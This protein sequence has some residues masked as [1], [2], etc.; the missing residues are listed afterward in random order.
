MSTSSDPKS[1]SEK[2]VLKKPNMSAMSMKKY[3]SI[4]D[5]INER[6]DEEDAAY[7]CQ[8]ICAILKFDPSIGLASKERNEYITSWRKQKMEEYG[9]TART[10]LKGIN[11]LPKS[12]N[13]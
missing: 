2:T 11:K 12:C 1:S 3:N 8:Q 6:C 5:V 13:N 7:I 10:I 9:V 4:K